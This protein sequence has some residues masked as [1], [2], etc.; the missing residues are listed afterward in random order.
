MYPLH[1]NPYSSHHIYHLAFSRLWLFSLMWAFH[2][3]LSSFPIIIIFSILSA[4]ISF[5]RSFIA[6]VLKVERERIIL[7]CAW[8]VVS[9]WVKIRFQ[10]RPSVRFSRLSSQLKNILWSQPISHF[11]HANTILIHSSHG[12]RELLHLYVLTLLNTILDIN[13][14]LLLSWLELHTS[15]ALLWSSSLCVSMSPQKL[16]CYHLSTRG[17]AEIKIGDVDMSHTYI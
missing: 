3:F 7:T 8:L 17:R 15:L 13:S 12:Q 2:T 5:L 11:L 10:R 4:N 16:L 1:G 14:F 9:G 6:W